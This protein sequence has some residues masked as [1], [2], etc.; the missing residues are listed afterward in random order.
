MAYQARSDLKKQ[1]P[2][3]MHL[4]REKQYQVGIDSNGDVEYEYNDSI[5]LNN[6]RRNSD[7][8]RVDASRV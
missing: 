6:H 8:P 5:Y 1:D 3:P 4:H 2:S 7:G